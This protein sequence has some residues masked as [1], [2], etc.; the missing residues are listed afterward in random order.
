MG[1]FHYILERFRA[2]W[3]PVRVR[4][5]RS[6]KDME[7]RSDSIGT[8]MGPGSCSSIPLKD[9]RSG[10]R[11]RLAGTP[12]A[13]VRD[14]APG[15]DVRVVPDNS[16][17][18]LTIPGDS[19]TTAVA[20]GG[21]G[22]DSIRRRF[23]A[24]S[25]APGGCARPDR[26]QAPEFRFRKILFQKQYLARVLPSHLRVICA[27]PTQKRRDWCRSEAFLCCVCTGVG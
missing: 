7:P 13:V 1:F 21:R 24:F 14:S 23:T 15:T 2:K 9:I 25:R 6:N 22:D 20:A 17:R 10:G 12:A 8:E 18:S 27:T 11:G 3:V 19:E 4:K 26:E 16:R 5:T